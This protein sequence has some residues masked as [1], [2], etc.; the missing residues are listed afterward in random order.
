MTIVGVSGSPI[1]NGN[2]DRIIKALLEQSGKEYIFVNLS[3]LR[4]DPCRACAH[5]C[6][7]TNICPLDDDLKPYFEPILNSEALV[8]GTPVNGGNING[9][10]F[11]FTTRLWCFH[12]V[13]NLLRD[14]P[15]LL[16]ATGLFKRSEYRVMTRFLERIP[17]ENVIGHIYYTSNIPPCYKCG[18]GNVCKVGG[19][20]AMVGRNEERLKKFKITPDK[21]KRWEDDC[22]T[23]EKV[24]RY[25]KILAEL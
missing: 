8:L 25:A 19:L 15:I 21:F 4:Y 22:E 1:V 20:W 6:A 7:K 14:K 17:S 3:T 13:K 10:M 2:T 11:S 16:V 12:H 5:L 9:W 18:M 24:A 23:V